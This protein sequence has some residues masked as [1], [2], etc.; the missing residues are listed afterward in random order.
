M[1]DNELGLIKEL[2]YS[3][4]APSCSTDEKLWRAPFCTWPRDEKR[5]IAFPLQGAA[6]LGYGIA[7][8]FPSAISLGAAILAYEQDSD[9]QGS[10]PPPFLPLGAFIKCPSRI[11]SFFAPLPRWR[12]CGRATPACGCTTNWAPRTSCGRRRASPRCSLPRSSTTSDSVSTA[13]PRPSSS[14][15]SWG[16]CTCPAG[17]WMR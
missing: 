14:S 3:E 9:P 6:I 7:S 5:L 12:R 8:A 13:F 1:R 10:S 17:R 15:C 4:A 2:L 16:C 11:P